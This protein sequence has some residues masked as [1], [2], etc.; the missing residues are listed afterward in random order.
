MLCLGKNEKLGLDGGHVPLGS[1]R[2]YGEVD[3]SKNVKDRGNLKIYIG[4]K[5]LKVKI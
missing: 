5:F 2:G 3:G 4:R 1:E